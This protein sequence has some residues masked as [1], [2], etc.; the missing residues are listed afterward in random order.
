MHKKQARKLLTET[1]RD[2]HTIVPLSFYF[3]ERNL[4]K[5]LNYLSIM[6]VARCNWRCA[7]VRPNATSARASRNARCAF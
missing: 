6:I 5:V 7:R 3:N 1:T 2:G 4:L